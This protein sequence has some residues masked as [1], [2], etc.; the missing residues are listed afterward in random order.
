MKVK[1]LLFVKM[2]SLSQNSFRPVPHSGLYFPL[3]WVS[4]FA[5]PR[6]YPEARLCHNNPDFSLFPPSVDTN[7]VTDTDM[8]TTTD[9][10]TVGDAGSV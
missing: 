9:T 8:D 2:S 4:P 7:R 3:G 5:L 10:D 6:V 1:M